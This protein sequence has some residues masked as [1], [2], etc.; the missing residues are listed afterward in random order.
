[1]RPNAKNPTTRETLLAMQYTLD[2]IAKFEDHVSPEERHAYRDEVKALRRQ[3]KKI[4]RHLAEDRPKRV[5][6]AA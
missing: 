3:F 1:M 2:M 4:Q 5:K 6:L